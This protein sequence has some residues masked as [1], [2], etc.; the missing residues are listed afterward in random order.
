MGE[1]KHAA[2]WSLGIAAALMLGTTAIAPI[3]QMPVDAATTTET[4]TQNTNWQSVKQQLLA[5]DLLANAVVPVSWT[6]PV[7]QQS[8]SSLTVDTQTTLADL[9]QNVQSGSALD[10]AWAAIGQ[11]VS[12]RTAMAVAGINASDL[13]QGSAAVLANQSA[14]LAGLFNAPI[15]IAMLPEVAQKMTDT[16][17]APALTQLQITAAAQGWQRL[18]II[19]VAANGQYNVTDQPLSSLVAAASSPADLNQR[20]QQV[21]D[22]L[23]WRMALQVTDGLTP[24]ALPN[25]ASVE[26]AAFLKSPAK[27]TTSTIGDALAAKKDAAAFAVGESVPAYTTLFDQWQAVLTANKPEQGA[28]GEKDDD[29]T[30]STPSLTVTPDDHDDSGTPVAGPDA[31]PVTDG[32]TPAKPTTDKPDKEDTKTPAQGGPVLTLAPDDSKTTTMPRKAVTVTKKD[33]SKP[34]I[35]LNEHITSI[36]YENYSTN[37]TGSQTTLPQTGETTRQ[38]AWL[39]ISGL[40]LLAFVF[41][42]AE[43]P[44]RLS[45]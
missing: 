18:G 31:N 24:Q 28:D 12:L 3:T 7:L 14:S 43:K 38:E 13:P 15:N 27:T 16:V 22:Q 32:K 25:G 26:L 20:V 30:P 23:T 8:G 36:Q 44:R 17:L 29:K 39:S 1:K 9:V 34:V 42:V 5:T 41:V 19:T 6:T 40:V 4:S 33:D 2:V 35:T 21:L 37:T 11:Q 10:T 45:E